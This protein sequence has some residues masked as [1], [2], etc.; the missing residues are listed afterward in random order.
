MCKEKCEQKCETC[1]GI[2]TLKPEPEWEL[3]HKDQKYA[4]IPLDQYKK[5][6]KYL[7]KQKRVDKQN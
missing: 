3:Y 2:P 6:A 4:I 1:L 5:I 7:D